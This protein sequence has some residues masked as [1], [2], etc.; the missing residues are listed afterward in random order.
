MSKYKRVVHLRVATQRGRKR[1]DIG[2]WSIIIIF[3]CHGSFGLFA[4]YGC[5]RLAIFLPGEVE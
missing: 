5:L 2:V 4:T 1:P 3:V